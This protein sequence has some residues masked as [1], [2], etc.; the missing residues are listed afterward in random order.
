MTS[1]KSSQIPL[2]QFSGYISVA[3][4]QIMLTNACIIFSCIQRQEPFHFSSHFLESHLGSLGLKY[5]THSLPSI[6]NIVLKPRQQ[7]NANKSLMIGNWYSCLLW[8][9]A[10]A[11]QIQKWMLT[12]IH[13]TEHKVPNEGARESTQGAKRVWSPIGG[14]SIW[15]NQYP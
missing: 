7:A 15:T 4:V 13:W 1:W 5:R 10:S 14:T 8:G 6:E 11:W 9:S 12:V 3:Y 2:F